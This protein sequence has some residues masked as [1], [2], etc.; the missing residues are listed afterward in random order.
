MSAR[1]PLQLG[2]R[3]QRVRG[4]DLTGTIVAV[5]EPLPGAFRYRVR[6][7]AE[8]PNSI[9]TIETPDRLKRVR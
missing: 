6:W 7:G 5:L 2:D 4:N 9:H 3:V 1:R 8:H